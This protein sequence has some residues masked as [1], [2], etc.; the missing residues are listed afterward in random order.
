MGMY[1]TYQ[2]LGTTYKLWQEQSACTHTGSQAKWVSLQLASGTLFVRSLFSASILDGNDKSEVG[3]G[4]TVIGNERLLMALTLTDI[5]KL[6]LSLFSSET[7][8]SFSGK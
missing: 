4:N 5:K 2:P 8:R 6:Y 7:V 3:R 1:R